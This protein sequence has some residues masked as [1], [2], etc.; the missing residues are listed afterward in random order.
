MW[1]A[2]SIDLK[3]ARPNPAS[4]LLSPTFAV[5]AAALVAADCSTQNVPAPTPSACR[6]PASAPPAPPLLTCPR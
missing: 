6:E 4:P 5:A 3:K 1:R 2:T